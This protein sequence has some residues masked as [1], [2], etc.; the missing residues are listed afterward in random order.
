MEKILDTRVLI[1]RIKKKLAHKLKCSWYIV[2]KSLYCQM[3][4]TETILS[5][6]H[7]Y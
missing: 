5:L 4:K 1:S 3:T 2:Y 6:I 7:V